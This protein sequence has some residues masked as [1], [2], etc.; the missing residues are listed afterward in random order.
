M[1]RWLDWNGY[2]TIDKEFLNQSVDDD[3]SVGG[4]CC[5]TAMIH[6][7]DLVVSNAGDCRAVMSRGG[8]AWWSNYYLDPSS[9]ME[10]LKMVDLVFC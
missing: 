7:S 8:V 4:A 9:E 1:W 6:E 2:F 3:H 5:V 10:F